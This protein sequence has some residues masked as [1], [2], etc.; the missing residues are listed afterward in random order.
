MMKLYD[1]AQWLIVIGVVVASALYMVG[2]I[3]PQWRVR[4]A[5]HLQQPR[6]AHWIN[7]FGIRMA[8]GVGCG[9]CDSCGSCSPSDS[10]KKKHST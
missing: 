1:I 9:S 8:G 6:Y 5:Q 7:Q 10:S 2:R 3:V 4:L